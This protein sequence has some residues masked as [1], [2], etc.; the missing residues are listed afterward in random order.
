MKQSRNNVFETNS[1]SVHAISINKSG[2]EPS[3]LTKDKNNNIVVRLGFFSC[4]GE[5]TTQNEKMSYL[6][7]SMYYVCPD[8][9]L[10]NNRNYTYEIVKDTI[11]TYANA[12]D[13][14][15]TGVGDAYIDHQSLPRDDSDLIINVYDEETIIDFIFNKYVTVKMY[16]D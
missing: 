9:T 2:L 13:I 3:K 1:S 10:E 8:I 16:R 14:V 12:S 6:M 4:D 7:T 11:C 15:L 5:L